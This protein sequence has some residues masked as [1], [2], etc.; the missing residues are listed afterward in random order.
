M[1][2]AFLVT[3]VNRTLLLTDN[4]GR[5]GPNAWEKIPDLFPQTS[6][7]RLPDGRVLAAGGE[8]PMGDDYLL[9]SSTEIF[10]PETNTWSPDPE[11][12]QPRSSHSDT[13]MLD[14]SILLAGGISQEGERYPIASTEFITP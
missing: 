12:S 7:A 10:D 4:K 5:L 14:G 13:L 1:K 9:Y 2:S 11:L 8:D 3:W 6:P